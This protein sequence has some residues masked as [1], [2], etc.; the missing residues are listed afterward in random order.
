M[1]EKITQQM[2]D[3]LFPALEALETQSAALLLLIKDKGL[4]SEEEIASYFEQAGSAS[5]VRWRAA[6][7]RINYLLSTAA[8]AEPVTRTTPAKAI[9]K[10]STLDATTVVE[11]VAKNDEGATSSVQG[12]TA[13][14][15]EDQVP[16]EAAKDAAKQKTKDTELKEGEA[17][18]AV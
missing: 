2:L 17:K 16:P 9:E 18:G 11:T 7:A 1:D 14:T 8:N 10:D 13:D 6:R 12:P 15:E 5:S 3:G 4:A